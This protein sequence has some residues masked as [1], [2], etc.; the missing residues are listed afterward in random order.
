LNKKPT[1]D[2][3]EYINKYQLFFLKS[4]YQSLIYMSTDMTIKP[5]EVLPYC[6]RWTEDVK[7]VLIDK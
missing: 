7:I 4:L 2:Q 6:Q 5:R 3:K 1:K